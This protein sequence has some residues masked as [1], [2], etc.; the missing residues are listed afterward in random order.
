MPDMGY[1]TP[2]PC[3]IVLIT[4]SLLQLDYLVGRDQI[5]SFEQQEGRSFN[6]R[7]GNASIRHQIASNAIV[8]EKLEYKAVFDAVNRAESS[9]VVEGGLEAGLVVHLSI[10]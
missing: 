10:L 1:A 7:L 8:L 6:S 2:S 3:V 5:H 4:N 9:H